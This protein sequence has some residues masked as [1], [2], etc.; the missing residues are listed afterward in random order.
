MPRKSLKT[1]A[2]TVAGPSVEVLDT[3]PLA[4]L[5]GNLYEHMPS[6]V[7][8]SRIIFRG[9]E[10]VDRLYLYTNPAYRTQTGLDNLVG[11]LVSDVRPNGEADR[12]RGDESRFADIAIARRY[13]AVRGFFR[14]VS[15]RSARIRAFT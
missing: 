8:C 9:N 11:R 3:P 1:L 5:L 12:C 4:E 14:R 13:P 10:P 15:K 7:C 2:L 6:G